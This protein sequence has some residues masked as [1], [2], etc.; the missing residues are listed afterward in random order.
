MLPPIGAA[1]SASVD[2]QTAGRHAARPPVATTAAV[3]VPSVS[4]PAGYLSGGRLEL[5]SLSGQM[6]VAQGLSIFAETVGNYLKIGRREGESLVDYAH[7]LA[8]AVKSLTAAQRSVLEQGLAHLMRGLTLRMLAEILEN[9]LGPEAARL[10]IFIEA[11]QFPDRDPATR[12]VVSSYRQNAASDMLAGHPAS[13]GLPSSTPYQHGATSRLP[14]VSQSILAARPAG[15]AGMSE[16]V[17]RVA[18]L[19][20]R[21]AGETVLNGSAPSRLPS[22]PDA[23]HAEPVVAAKP[24]MAEGKAP[25]LREATSPVRIAGVTAS[26]THP[27]DE[28]VENDIPAQERRRDAP[29]PRAGNTAP[30]EASRAAVL[31]GTVV[32][33]DAPALARMAQR[34]EE[35]KALPQD[36]R[37]LAG[38]IL[39]SSPVA[40][41]PGSVKAPVSPLRSLSG[42]DMSGGSDPAAEAPGLSGIVAAK[43]AAPALLNTDAIPSAALPAPALS[44]AAQEGGVETLIEQVLF[45]SIAAPTV[46]REGL[47]PAFVAYPT[48]SGKPDEEERDVERLSP[49]DEDGGG[50]HAGHDRREEDEETSA[51]NEE[52]E[53]GQAADPDRLDEAQDLYWRMADLA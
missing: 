6:H 43:P 48:V 34:L 28:R 31:R 42:A 39:G 12:A 10:N 16:A 23:P 17:G 45:L 1:S 25:A 33:Y 35:G 47:V 53:E 26:T 22:S 18:A 3:V 52:Q 21:P 29:L 4:S 32:I 14:A 20:R 51:E 50:H 37:Y 19:E 9:P 5:L 49:V 38:R 13:L 15:E 11:G 24:E 46:V 41:E 36:V 7:R 40:V 44:H 30:A 8:E 2:Y 27:R